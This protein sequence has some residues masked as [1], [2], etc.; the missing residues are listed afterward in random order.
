MEF[1]LQFGYGM[2]DHCRVLMSEWNEGTVIL[3]PRDLNDKQLHKLASDLKN[4]NTKVL[5]DPQFYLPHSDHHRLRSHDY[6]PKEYESSGFWGGKEIEILISRLIDLNNNL[7]CYEFILPGL[8]ASKIDSHWLNRQRSVIDEAERV[9]INLNNAFITVSLS[10]DAIKTDKQIHTLLEESKKWP[11]GGIYLICEHPNGNYFVDDPVWL[12]NVLDLIAGFRLNGQR[13]I[14]GYCNQQMLITAC[15][16]VTSIASGTWAN[17][18]SFLPA[19]FSSQYE[20]E[21]K[22]RTVWYYCPQTLSE[23]TIP[24]LDIAKRQNILSEMAPHDSLSNSYITNLFKS[25]QPS[26]IDFSEQAAFRHYLLTLRQQAITSQFDTFDETLEYHHGLLDKAE[27]ILSELHSLG[28]RGQQRDFYKSL[29][30][31]RAALS[32]LNTNRGPLLRR[33]WRQLNG[34]N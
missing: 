23:F 1:S 14:L 4:T 7:S 15:A 33:K 31:N 10:E 13:V 12:A 30:A 26:S 5:F 25:E 24:F 9:N 18:R 22:Q 29:D 28:V 8:Y 17:V 32:V 21:I 16:G 3:S 34:I 27:N 19:K 6:W 20:Q 2:M 11:I